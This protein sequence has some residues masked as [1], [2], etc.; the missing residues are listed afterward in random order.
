MFVGT[1]ALAL[2]KCNFNNNNFG[3]V[4]ASFNECQGS[5]PTLPWRFVSPMRVESL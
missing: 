1:K 2:I 3:N 4:K 5:Q